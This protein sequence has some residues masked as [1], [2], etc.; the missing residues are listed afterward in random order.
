MAHPGRRRETRKAQVGD[1][2]VERVNRDTGGLGGIRKNNWRQLRGLVGPMR[3][4]R[5]SAA[6]LHVGLVGGEYLERR[7]TKSGAGLHRERVSLGVVGGRNLEILESALAASASAGQVLGR[8]LRPCCR[9]VVRNVD[10]V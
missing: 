10:R 2:G 3:S 1:G 4:F 6:H 8:L 7:W 5:L 9:R